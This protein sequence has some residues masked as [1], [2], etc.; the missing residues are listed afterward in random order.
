L[1]KEKKMKVVI[2]TA[3][4]DM[5]DKG[6]FFDHEKEP[7]LT[8]QSEKDNCDINVLMEKYQKSGVLPV[9]QTSPVYGDFSQIPDYQDM[10]NR[11]IDAENAFMALPAK[12]R[13]EFDDD[14]AEFMDFIHDPKN[15]DRLVEMGLREAPKP[16]ESPIRVE[17]VSPPQKTEGPL[18]GPP[19]A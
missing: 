3:Y 14:P 16:P 17:V 9:V 15:A 13:R 18:S 2:R 5:P 6:L 11:L 4:D 19:A 7:S 12:I 1:I 10:R 8:V